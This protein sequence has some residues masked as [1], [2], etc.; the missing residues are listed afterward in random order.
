MTQVP[1]TDGVRPACAGG[2][3]GEDGRPRS[4]PPPDPMGRPARRARRRSG[5]RALGRWRPVGG[6]IRPWS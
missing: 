5:A 6:R 2:G 3:T 1:V 4:R